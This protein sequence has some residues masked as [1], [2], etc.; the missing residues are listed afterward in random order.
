MQH[1]SFFSSFDQHQHDFIT[2]L[3][4]LDLCF[5]MFFLKE[6]AESCLTPV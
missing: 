2:Y 5:Y 6:F 1:F 4:D 3:V